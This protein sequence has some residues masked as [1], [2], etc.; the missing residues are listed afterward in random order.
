MFSNRHHQP[1]KTGNKIENLILRPLALLL[2]FTKG[3]SITPK[4]TA[5]RAKATTTTANVAPAGQRPGVIFV[6][7]AGYAQNVHNW[8]S[9]YYRE[10]MFDHLLASKGY[11][12]LD[13]DYRGSAGYGR[14]WRTAIYRHMGG[15]DLDDVMDGAHWL[16]HTLGIDSTRIG[17][18]GG[19]YGGFMTL[20]AMFK[21]PGIFA[22]GAAL[23]PVSN[24]ANYNNGYTARIL[25]DPQT[26]SI[27]YKQS[28]PIYFA[29]GLAGHLLI[30]HGLV[31][32]NVNFQDT[33][34]LVQRLIELGKQHWQ[35]AIYPV[36]R[37]GFVRADSWTDEYRR[38][39]ELFE[40]TLR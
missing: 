17:M 25:N 8:W 37:H 38:I 13:M 12:V 39:L 18:Y 6:H 19:S 5:G 9:S 11:T 20:M 10:Y 1:P 30:C 23:R 21:A 15:G 27:A 40:T 3:A 22:A 7:G 24:W 35:L 31:D 29:Q 4:P 16:V 14:D 33:V 26:D 28:S 34:E 32:D 36:E 2:V